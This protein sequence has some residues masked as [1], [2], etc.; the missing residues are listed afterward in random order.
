MAGQQQLQS[1]SS[2]HAAS[3][4]YTVRQQVT[5]YYHLL[6]H[7][8]DSAEQWQLIYPAVRQL[9]ELLNSC[10]DAAAWRI[11]YFAEHGKGN[12][13]QA[14]AYHLYHGALEWR[15]LDLCLQR[16]FEAN[17]LDT[18]GQST[19]L[20]QLERTLNDLVLCASYYHKSKH[21]AELLHTSAFM[22]RCS[23]E[24]W[25]WLLLHQQ[26]DTD[27]AFWPLFHRAMQRHKAQ[28]QR[29]FH[30]HQLQQESQYIVFCFQ[31]MPPA[32]PSP[33]MS[34]MPGCALAWPVWALTMQL[35]SSAY[36]RRQ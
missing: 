29:K 8:M 24:L 22:C 2:L 20:S 31:W 3:S 5:H 19:Y 6:L 34:F 18:A 26:T 11:L 4:W 9:R 32:P 7:D 17:A 16:K 23:K 21:S 35:E 36:N 27:T 13:C 15:L 14:P 30:R 1:K 10:L 28:L 33:T 12:E 25:L